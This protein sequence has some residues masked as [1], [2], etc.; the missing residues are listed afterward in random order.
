MAKQMVHK[1]HRWT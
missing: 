1:K